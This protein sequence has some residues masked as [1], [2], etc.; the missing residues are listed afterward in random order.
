MATQLCSR[1]V[2]RA[3]LTTLMLIRK[4]VKQLADLVVPTLVVL[5]SYLSMLGD[6]AFTCVM[7]S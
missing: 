2:V 5:M 6:A 1:A 3:L 4:M 7:F